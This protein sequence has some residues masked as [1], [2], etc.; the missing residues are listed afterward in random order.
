MHLDRPKGF[1]AQESPVPGRDTIQTVISPSLTPQAVH[2]TRLV[3]V[4]HFAEKNVAESSFIHDYVE[5]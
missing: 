3:N 1:S 2:R 4:K 5:Q